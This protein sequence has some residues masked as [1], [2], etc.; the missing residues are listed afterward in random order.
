VGQLG[1]FLALGLGLVRAASA[2]AQDAED[3]PFNYPSIP[4]AVANAEEFVSPGWLIASKAE[5]DLNRDGRADVAM[6]LW[7]EQ[8]AQAKTREEMLEAPSYRLVIAFSE[9]KGGY[10]LVTDIK[11]LLE[12]PDG[13]GNLDPLA[14]DD[15][16]VVRGSL[17]IS[18]QLLRGHYR[19][20]FRWTNGAIRMIGYDYGGSNGHCVTVTSINYLTRKAVVETEALDET[21]EA[22]RFVRRIKKPPVSIE[23]ASAEGFYPERDMAGPDTYC[24]YRGGRL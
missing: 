13:W 22:R 11:S 19:Y 18:R 5:G 7:T 12:A 3:P 15:L 17:D 10:R 16:R 20:R 6:A 21:G 14:A 9:P 2:A 1:R 8:A 4:R 24:A 23:E